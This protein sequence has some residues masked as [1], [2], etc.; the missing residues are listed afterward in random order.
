MLCIKL[1]LLLSEILMA[2]SRSF[3]A[4]GLAAF[5][6]AGASNVITTCSEGTSFWRTIAAGEV[7][8][9]LLDRAPSAP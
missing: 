3:L 1:V 7:P 8:I 5:A 9:V 2:L 6:D 4:V